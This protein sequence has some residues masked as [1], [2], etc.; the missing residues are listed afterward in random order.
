MTHKSSVDLNFSIGLAGHFDLDNERHLVIV[1][2]HSLDVLVGKLDHLRFGLAL[3]RTR[4]QF[5][6]RIGQHDND[7]AMLARITRTMRKHGLTVT[8]QFIYILYVVQV[9][10]IFAEKVDFDVVGVRC[11]IYLVAIHVFGRLLF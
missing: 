7:V 5:E 8:V 3:A 11:Y 9:A 6:A 10:V 2:V 4:L 1:D